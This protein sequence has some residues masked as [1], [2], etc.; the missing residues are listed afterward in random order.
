MLQPEPRIELIVNGRK[1]RTAARTMAELVDEQELAASKVA[2]ALNGHFVP[3]A[4]ACYDGAERWRPRRDR[5]RAP[6][7]LN[8]GLSEFPDTNEHSR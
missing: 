4:A 2:T 7:R 3:E 5:L 1:A 6:G 8:V